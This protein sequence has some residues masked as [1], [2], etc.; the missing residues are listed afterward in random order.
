MSQTLISEY[1]LK[2]LDKKLL[3]NKLCEMR[4]ILEIN[5]AKMIVNK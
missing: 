4:K 2:L 3:E 1:K 5:E